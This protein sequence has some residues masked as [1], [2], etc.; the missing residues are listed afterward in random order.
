MRIRHYGILGNNCRKRDIQAA[1]AIFERRGHAL[2]LQPRSDADKSM[3]CPSCG[4]VGI[5]P[6]GL[7]R[8]RGPSTPDRRPTNAPRFLMNSPLALIST[9]VN[10]H[11]FRQNS[12]WMR[13]GCPVHASSAQVW[14]PILLL[15]RST[16][17][18]QKG[19]PQLLGAPYN[20]F[21]Q[22]YSCRDEPQ[23]KALL[24]AICT[25]LPSFQGTFPRPS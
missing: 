18:A 13:S 9:A 4:K 22:R 14:L 3:S 21:L 11:A 25:P 24:A 16:R 23:S 1:R 17:R 19:Q 12:L 10:N 8:H 6:G 2:E 7:Y 15:G 5:S 20:L